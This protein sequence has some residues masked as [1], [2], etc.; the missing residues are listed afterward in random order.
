MQT[1]SCQHAQF[2][3]VAADLL[4]KDLTVAAMWCE[5]D[6]GVRAADLDVRYGV[7]HGCGAAERQHADVRLIVPRHETP[8]QA[9][10]E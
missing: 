6:L 8:G 5:T 1:S 9:R 4:Q 3:E 2:D 7:G 10:S